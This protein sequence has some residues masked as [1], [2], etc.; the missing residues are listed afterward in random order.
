MNEI[1]VSSFSLRAELGP[2]SF[3]SLGVD[4]T[5]RSIT[6]DAE[7]QLTLAEFAS[8]ARDS[9]GVSLIEICQVQVADRSAG[10]IDAIR[11]GMWRSGVELLTVPIDVGDISHPLR[12]VRQRSIAATVMWFDFAAALDARF[13]RVN[14]VSPLESDGLAAP[15]AV[16]LDA[17][18]RLEDAAAQR[19]MG[20]LLENKGGVVR[21]SAILLELLDALADSSI[22]LILDT[23][24]F[25]PLA[26]AMIAAARG[27]QWEPDYHLEEVYQQI[28]M[29][30]PHATVVHA[31]AH[32]F[33][34]DNVQGP[35]DLGRA[36]RIVL[37]TGFSGP[38]T[39][40][41]EGHVGDPWTNTMAAVE[42]VRS[43]LAAR[44]GG[45]PPR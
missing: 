44:A 34:A 11:A 14:A 6:I 1:A 33:D 2:V 35:M 43:V 3:T 10:A 17:L 9:G 45:H 39:V 31:K 16:T 37:A 20:L 12:E 15:R 28:E 19:G 21:Y 27:M 7:P 36:L 38:I 18:R 8:K 25:E 24:N 41:Y 29:L 32:G 22:G 40:E 42:I 23:G 5:E 30:A 13:V 26:S 4:G